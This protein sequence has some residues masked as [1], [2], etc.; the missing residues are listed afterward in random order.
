MLVFLFKN[1]KRE[2]FLEFGKSRYLNLIIILFIFICIF[3][4]IVYFLVLIIFYNKFR[5]IRGIIIIYI[6]LFIK[7]Y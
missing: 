4:V 6:V 2:D 5:N 7:L 1:G 3:L